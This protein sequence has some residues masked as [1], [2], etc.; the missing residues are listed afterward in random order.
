[1]NVNQRKCFATFFN[2]HNCRCWCDQNFELKSSR[3]IC[4]SLNSAVLISTQL[5]VENRKEIDDIIYAQKFFM[6]QRLET[7][8]VH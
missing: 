7:G 5:S 2:R 4:K 3:N 8:V 6:K 1:M